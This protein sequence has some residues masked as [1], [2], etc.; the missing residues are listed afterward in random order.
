MRSEKIVQSVQLFFESQILISE[1]LTK[2]SERLIPQFLP[3]ENDKHVG[4][5]W[6]S[7]VDDDDS[8]DPIWGVAIN[9]PSQLCAGNVDA[10]TFCIRRR[11][12]PSDPFD[13]LIH[14]PHDFVVTR[15]QNHLL[16]TKIDSVNP[17]PDTIDID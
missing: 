7:L 11:R 16:R 1:L 6:P 2:Y 9:T 17:V 3:H 5:D 14:I 10:Q 12:F 8:A 13:R 15:D 4:K